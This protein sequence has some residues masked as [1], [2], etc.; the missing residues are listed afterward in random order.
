MRPLQRLAHL[1][2]SQVLLA[3]VAGELVLNRLAV[4]ALRPPGGTTPPVWHQVLDHL[5]LYAFHFAS[6]LAACA[7]LL[8]L[9]RGR[10]RPGALARSLARFV[11]WPDREPATTGAPAV[12]PVLRWI[13]T[14]LAAVAGLA[15]TLPAS[16]LMAFALQSAFAA[17]LAVLVLHQIGRGGDRAAK[18]GIALVISPL[19]LHYWSPFAARVLDSEEALWGGLQ[20]RVQFIGQWLMVIAALAAP[21]CFA[22]RPRLRAALQL[23]PLVAASFI[24]TV[25]VLILRQHYEVGMLL[26]SRGLGI[27]IGPGAPT[28]QIALY[29]LALGS[30]TWTLAAG[31]LAPAPARR[32]IA[33]GIGLIAAGGYSFA[34]PLQYLTCTVGVL[35]MNRAARRLPED[36]SD[37]EESRLHAPPVN[38][39]TWDSYVRAL[40]AALQPPGST[41]TTGAAP[42]EAPAGR[43]ADA[44]APGPAFAPAATR[45]LTS[46]DEDVTHTHIVTTRRGCGIALRIE[47][48]RRCITAIELTVGEIPA[49]KEPD[50]TLNA[51][52]E[53][54]LGVG[55]HP[56]APATSAPVRKTG[57]T[58]F[59]RR[60]RVHDRGDLTDRLFDDGLRARTTALI[61]GWMACWK[62]TALRYR[63]HPGQGAPLDHPIAISE[64]AVRGVDAPVSAERLV[65]LIDLVAELGARALPADHPGTPDR[66]A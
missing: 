3:I 11:E 47:R 22:P 54:G 59:D 44:P 64:L 48:V 55:V 1:P 5:G 9:W 58:G 25:G 16:E 42:G 45:I 36:Q 53:R 49:Q 35:V 61:D 32:E 20:E 60:F 2:P 14:G 6:T 40:L 33:M 37:R 21:F 65:T 7:L 4:P 24:A 41:G 56:P 13:G 12:H 19:L 43:E 23:G 26:A 57:D 17:T 27:D 46:R 8:E 28:A 51:R 31:L 10:S 34:W 38:D 29:L 62:D 39:E 15:I 66:D 63:V 18:I 50:W 52:P 30:I